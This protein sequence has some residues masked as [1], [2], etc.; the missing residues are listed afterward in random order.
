[1]IKEFSQ[2]LGVESDQVLLVASLFGCMVLSSFLRFIE[3]PEFRV[4]YCLIAAFPIQYSL[5]GFRIMD[6]IVSNIGCILAIWFLPRRLVGIINTLFVTSHLVYIHYERMINNYGGWTID[7]SFIYMVTFERWTAF[8]F[9]FSDG[10]YSDSQNEFAI[11]ED[12]KL[13]EFLS[14]IH[15]LPCCVTGPFAEYN[16]FMDFVH[17]RKNYKNIEYNYLNVFKKIL[18]I[19][20]IMAAY[21]LLQPYLCVDYFFERTDQLTQESNW[22]DYIK[23]YGIFFVLVEAKMKYYIG[24]IFCECACD[25]SGISFD[26]SMSGTSE[27]NSK[28]RCVRVWDCETTFNVK[29]FFRCWNISTHDWLKKYVFKRVIGKVGKTWAE[30][31]TFVASSSW[32][33]FYFSYHFVFSMIIVMQTAQEKI[34]KAQRKIE[35]T[36]SFI[37]VKKAINALIS[38]VHY[39]LILIIYNYLVI[40]L[41]NLDRIKFFNITMRL[42]YFPVYC[43]AALMLVGYSLEFATKKIGKESKI[44]KIN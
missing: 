44:R 12:F 38:I 40:A 43:I 29:G 37:F 22:I 19:I 31:I 24:F 39:P 32:H 5:Y 25:V 42:N 15:F 2:T 14:Y 28:T 17:L 8:S 34:F 9:N 26:E 27:A 1:M 10:E 7:V 41:W 11:K 6:L 21:V 23:A 16:D 36:T 33:G 4:W 3:K 30:A 13:A 18:L 20:F 35:S